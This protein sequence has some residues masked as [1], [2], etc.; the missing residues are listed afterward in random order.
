MKF[1]SIRVPFYFN[2]GKGLVEVMN[3]T[4]TTVGQIQV[5]FLDF[6]DF[7]LLKRKEIEFSNP[8]V[9]IDRDNEA[10]N[11]FRKQLPDSIHLHSLNND[12]FNPEIYIV[13]LENL[14]TSN[15]IIN[16][17]EYLDFDLL[18]PDLKI[19]TASLA[20]TSPKALVE[21]FE[22]SIP[23]NSISTF[24]IQPEII[25]SASSRTVTFFVLVLTFLVI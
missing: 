9:V 22:I 19:Y 5:S 20:G 23:G 14:S 4:D 8:L 3:D 21:N 13:R 7:E 25:E 2:L 16:M 17:G 6:R 11:F 18:G 24:R 10:L 1:Y 12:V 15:I